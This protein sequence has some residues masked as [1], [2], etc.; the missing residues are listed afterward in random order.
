ME[1]TEEIGL[2]PDLS[3]LLDAACDGEDELF[4]EV[5]E[6]L[7]GDKVPLD[8]QFGNATSWIRQN[9]FRDTL[10]TSEA[11]TVVTDI[12]ELKTRVSLKGS[13][14]STRSIDIKDIAIER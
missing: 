2:D 7:I 12:Q 8:G 9:A 13:S 1:V 5:C 10:E 3:E 6:T 11:D 4:E 14:K